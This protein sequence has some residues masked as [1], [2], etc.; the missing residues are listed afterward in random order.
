MSGGARTS[1]SS[2]STRFG[3]LSGP[4]ALWDFSADNS[5][6]T[7]SLLMVRF[8]ILA[9]AGPSHG[10][11]VTSSLEKTLLNSFRSS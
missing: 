2:F 8:G 1:A 7:P 6:A 9:L 10:M 4:A 3:N 5:F 11:A